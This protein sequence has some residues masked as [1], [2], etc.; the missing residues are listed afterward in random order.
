MSEEMTMKNT[1]PLFQVDA[2]ARE[3][4]NGR[5]VKYEHIAFSERIPPP[6]GATWLR[7]VRETMSRRGV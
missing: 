3:A 4:V 6:F 2:L 7:S 5:R 1:I